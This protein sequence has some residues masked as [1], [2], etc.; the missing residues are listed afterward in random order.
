MAD[1][2]APTRDCTKYLTWLENEFAPRNLV[3]PETTQKQQIENAIRYW[4][5]HSAYKI[6][7]MLDYDSRDRRF[8]LNNQIKTVIQVLPCRST[9]WGLY[10]HPLWTLLAVTVI[11]NVTS[12]L[13]L[14]TEAFK[15]YRTYIGS[16]M[17]W[18]FEKSDDH[19]LGGYLYVYNVPAGN[20]K[21][22]VI[23]IKR[24]TKNEDIKIEIVENWILY[25]TKALVKQIEG[26][27]LRA[28]DIIDIKNDGQRLLEEGKEEQ[29][30][31]QEQL[32]QE[33]VWTAFIRRR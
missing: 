33:A 27:T 16:D 9:A 29:K 2:L 25:Y 10:G 14:L 6:T 11:D 21:L 12:D 3:T 13:I 28:A 4:N 18:Q 31:L 19:E 1:D 17:R 20:E 15:N 26:N 5:T 22:A 23:G 30:D 7:T 32:K 24:I 8:Q